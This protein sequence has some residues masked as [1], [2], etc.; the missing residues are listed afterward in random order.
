[1]EE[2]RPTL[3]SSLQV[4]K[5]DSLQPA[6]V[7]SNASPSSSI[8]ILNEGHPSITTASST[9]VPLKVPPEATSTSSSVCA[10]PKSSSASSDQDL[11]MGDPSHEGSTRGVPLDIEHVTVEDDPRLWSRTRKSCIL[12]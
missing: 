10:I 11:E 5:D 9:S 12:A 8:T 3:D 4:E 1:M 7:D 2:A 6:A